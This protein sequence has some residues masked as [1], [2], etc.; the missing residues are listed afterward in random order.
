MGRAGYVLVGLGNPITWSS[1]CH[2]AGRAR[3]RH[4][5]LKSWK[6]RNLVDYMKGQGVQVMASSFR[7]IAEEMPD[8]YK[9]VDLVVEAVEEAK[10]ANRVARLSPRLVVK[11]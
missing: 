3:S 2:G 4:Q 8:A 5:S 10:L 6:G 7:T 9:D 1:S 11:G